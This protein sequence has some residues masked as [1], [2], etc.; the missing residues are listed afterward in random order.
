MRRTRPVIIYHY[1]INPGFIYD[2]FYENIVKL[3]F[4][5]PV[6][7]LIGAFNNLEKRYICI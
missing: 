7:V 2:F 5:P 6:L 4:Q 3:V 1:F